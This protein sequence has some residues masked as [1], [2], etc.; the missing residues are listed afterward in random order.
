MWKNKKNKTRTFSWLSHSPKMHLLVLSGLACV[1]SACIGINGGK[2]QTKRARETFN[3]SKRLLRRL[4]QACQTEM[5]DFATL[6][7]TSTI[8]IPTLSYTWS[9]IKVPH[10][11]GA[12]PY[13]PLWGVPPLGGICRP[14][15]HVFATL[16]KESVRKWLENGRV[17]FGQLAV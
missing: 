3:T 9:L 17:C 10:S 4:S 2:K 6:S 13:R 12:S 16:L 5:V 1:A 14:W 8:E 7:F 11:G 15:V